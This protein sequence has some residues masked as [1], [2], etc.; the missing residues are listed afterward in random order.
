MLIQGAAD[1]GMWCRGLRYMDVHMRNTSLVADRLR[2]ADA[3]ANTGFR[4]ADFGLVKYSPALVLNVRRLVTG[5]ERWAWLCGQLQRI[6]G[7]FG[8]EHS[9]CRLIS[10]QISM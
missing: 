7:T 4:K 5:P 9:S 3:L 2:D 1:I 8:C 6:H 10:D